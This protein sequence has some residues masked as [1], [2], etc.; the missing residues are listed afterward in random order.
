MR[1]LMSDP[2][3]NTVCG[4][5]CRHGMKIEGEF[6]YK[7]TGWCSNSPYILHH[8]DKLCDNAHEHTFAEIA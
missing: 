3:V 1:E 7:P 5:M 6:V 2:T 4:D 8:M